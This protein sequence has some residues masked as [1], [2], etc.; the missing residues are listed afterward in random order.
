M[1]HNRPA[2]LLGL[3]SELLDHILSDLR[4]CDLANL[5]QSCRYFN[6][7]VHGSLQSCGRVIT[8]FQACRDG[9]REYYTP[10]DAT[11]I[12]FEVLS[13]DFKPDLLRILAPL[14][15]LMIEWGQRHFI[16]EPITEAIARFDENVRQMAVVRLGQ[17]FALLT[18]RNPDQWLGRLVDRNYGESLGQ[19]YQFL[20]ISILDRFI[21]VTTQVAPICV[22]VAC[23]V[24]KWDPD[25]H[26]DLSCLLQLWYYLK[27]LGFSQEKA[28]MR[29]LEN[30]IEVKRGCQRAASFD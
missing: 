5:D 14:F 27:S 10:M 13:H 25:S 17:L 20:A 26:D 22:I 8:L 18:T 4:L 21:E 19:R 23:N 30:Q 12:F 1:L 15:V 11:N 3:P 24:A 6:T 16:K 9:H 29:G 2:P 28:W 7:Y